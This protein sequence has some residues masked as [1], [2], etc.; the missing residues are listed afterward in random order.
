[1]YI[2]ISIVA[3]A[4]SFINYNSKYVAFIAK[5]ERHRVKLE[6]ITNYVPNQ[7]LKYLGIFDL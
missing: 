3:R 6:V 1:M 2:Y 4:G 7:N 5:S